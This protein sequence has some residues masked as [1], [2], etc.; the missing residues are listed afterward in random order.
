MLYTTHPA[1][2]SMGLQFRLLPRF[3]RLV[4]TIEL[5]EPSGCCCSSVALRP[6]VLASQWKR[7]GR[8]LSI[9]ASRSAKTRIDGA[10]SSAK[11]AHT[12]FSIVGVNLNVALFLSRAVIGRIRRVMLGRNLR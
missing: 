7:N 6:S 8:Y 10:A 9:I 4:K 12:T 11:R 3:A 1:S 5:M 2:N